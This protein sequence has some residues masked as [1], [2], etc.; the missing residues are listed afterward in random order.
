MICTEISATNFVDPV[1]DLDQ[2]K[3]EGHSDS[4]RIIRG[5]RRIT[6]TTSLA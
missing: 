5:G 2:A 6:A 3:K 4:A 1:I